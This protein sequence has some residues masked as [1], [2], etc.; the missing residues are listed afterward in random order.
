MN[1]KLNTEIKAYADN[2]GIAMNKQMQIGRTSINSFDQA[3][4]HINRAA[5]GDI[6][7]EERDTYATWLSKMFASDLSAEQREYLEK[8]VAKFEK[9]YGRTV[10]R[11]K[12]KEW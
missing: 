11:F 5:E 8:K 7:P 3:K 12:Q 2:S 1:N 9:K 10:T 6:G 4:A